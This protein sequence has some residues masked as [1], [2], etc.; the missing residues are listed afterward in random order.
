[1]NNIQILDNVDLQRASKISKG[2]KLRL[3]ESIPKWRY[4]EPSDTK[5]VNKKIIVLILV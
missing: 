3:H 4:V 5:K 2:K 1:M